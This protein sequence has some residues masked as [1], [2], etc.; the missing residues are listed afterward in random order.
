MDREQW[1]VLILLLTSAAVVYATLQISGADAARAV[2]VGILASLVIVAL[3]WQLADGVSKLRAWWQVTRKD[4]VDPE[5]VRP[6]MVSTTGTVSLLEGTVSAPYTDDDTE[7]VAYRYIQRTED[8]DGDMTVKKRTRE[9]VPF[10]VE[11]DHRGVAVDPGDAQLI[12]NKDEHVRHMSKTESVYH[13]DV[14][15]EVYVSGEAVSIHD[16]GVEIDDEHYGIRAPETPIPRVVANITDGG[17]I[18][19]D[20]PEQRAA[21][22]LLL[23]G[24]VKAGGVLMI[25]AIAVSAAV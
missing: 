5:R 14:D 8:E 2:A 22:G 19:A 12:L 20:G 3:L 23:R 6:G 25:V 15:D 18:V 13:L 9:A 1:A 10:V 24:V 16:L 21:W 4:A 11:G 17:L 7:T